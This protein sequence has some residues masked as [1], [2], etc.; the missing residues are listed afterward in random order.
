MEAASSVAAST[1]QTYGEAVCTAL[2]Q[3]LFDEL[4][5][6]RSSSSP[7]KLR[8]ELGVRTTVTLVHC[9]CSCR[10][11]MQAVIPRLVL[12]LYTAFGVG[13]RITAARALRGLVNGQLQRQLVAA[14]DVLP[15]LLMMVQDDNPSLAMAGAD[16]A[17]HLGGEYDTDDTSMLS[18]L[19]M[20]TTA[21]SDSAAALGAWP[22]R[23]VDYRPALN[24]QSHR[25][26]SVVDIRADAFDDPTEP[27]GSLDRSA[28]VEVYRHLVIGVWEVSGFYIHALTFQ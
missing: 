26:L 4:Q 19:P 17:T 23:V 2:M 24:S 1:M 28:H 8:S 15:P 3:R 27:S 21:V 18:M 10:T 5:Q 9:A 6:A 22:V 11:W 13:T 12:L 16:L 7:A 20:L 14:S 25:H